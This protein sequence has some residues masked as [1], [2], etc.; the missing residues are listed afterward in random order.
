MFRAYSVNKYVPGGV[1][2][3]GEHVTIS[4]GAELIVVLTQPIHMTHTV[5]N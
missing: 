5:I 1:R 3:M 2:R 4:S